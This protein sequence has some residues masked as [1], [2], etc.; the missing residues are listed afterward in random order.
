[1]KKIILSFVTVLVAGGVVIAGTNAFFSDTETSE[2]NILQAG[3]LDLKIDSEAHYDGLICTKGPDDRLVWR[4]DNDPNTQTTRPELI[5][6]DCVGTWSLKDLSEGDV[7]V[8]LTDLKPGDDG[9]NTIS[10]HVFDNDAW[11]R[12]R[13]KATDNDN[14]CTEP[15]VEVGPILDPECAAQGAAGPLSNTAGELAESLKFRVW[16]D[17]GTVPGFQ[18]YDKETG[19]RKPECDPT[20]GDNIRQ[21]GEPELGENA[22]TV[23][24]EITVIL[25]PALQQ[26]WQEFC[27]NTEG[28]SPDGHNDYGLC[29]GL[30][31]DGRLVGSVTY[32]LGVGWEIPEDV[33]NEI[34]TDSLTADIS[35]EVEQHRNNPTPFVQ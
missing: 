35:F 27:L 23:G 26:A 7:F 19:H 16:L 25:Y 20:E 5:G 12:I 13:I 2:G 31:R 24:G 33:G 8:N 11:G 6:E 4:E 14:G 1:M 17:Q 15:E 32:Y 18:C 3:A 34:Q 10:W 9:E 30:A 21:R 28:T 29:H 22:I